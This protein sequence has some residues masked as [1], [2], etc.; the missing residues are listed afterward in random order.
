MNLHVLKR[1]YVYA[2]IWFGVC[3]CVCASEATFIQLQF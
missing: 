1:Q 2:S 3:G